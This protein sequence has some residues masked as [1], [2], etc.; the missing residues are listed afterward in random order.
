MLTAPTASPKTDPGDRMHAAQAFSYVPLG[1]RE[2][3]GTQ[4]HSS[5]ITLTSLSL[6]LTHRGSESRGEE[7]ALHLDLP[8]PGVV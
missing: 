2:V 6:S 3:A 8:E 1:L 5:C 4:I 7:T